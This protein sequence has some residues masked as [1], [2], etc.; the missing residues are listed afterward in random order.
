MSIIRGVIFDLGSTL[1]RFEGD[2]DTV[3]EEGRQALVRSLISMGLPIDGGDFAAAFQREMEAS[4]Q[5]R[6]EDHVERPA[7]AV[8]QKVLGETGLA[9]IP[10][11]MI[12]RAL[13]EM[14][15][16]SETHWILMPD[17]HSVLRELQ[18]EAFRLGV[19]SNASDADDVNRLIDS[20][21]LRAYFDPILISAEFGRRKPDPSLFNSV[22]RAWALRPD[23]VVMVGD[24]LPH[25]ILGAQEV[26]LRHIWLTAQADTALNRA[27]AGRIV[28]E[29]VAS[30]LREV[31]GLIR[32]MSAD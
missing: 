3:I 18:G 13:R 21:N 23:E 14:F 32:R 19:I 12:R 15:L 24:T 30:E 4:L 7:G 20:S 29:A 9:G 27:Y 16:V 8:L 10:S 28:P 26:G 31:P 6:Q 22:L 11:D 5:E 2:W 17:A 1:F 25:D